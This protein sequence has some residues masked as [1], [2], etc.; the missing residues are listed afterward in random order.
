MLSDIEENLES[1]ELHLA[2]EQQRL[3]A[4]TSKLESH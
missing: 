4:I 2:A 3:T 1:S